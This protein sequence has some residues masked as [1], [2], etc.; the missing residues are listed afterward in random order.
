M[1]EPNIE[2]AKMHLMDAIHRHERHMDGREPTSRDSQMQMMKE[3]KMAMMAL[4]GA[5]V[6]EPRMG[7]MRRR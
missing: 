1:I 5:T 3:M 7:G 4:G 6:E 2:M